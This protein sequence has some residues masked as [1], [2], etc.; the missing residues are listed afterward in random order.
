MRAISI[1]ARAPNDYREAFLFLSRASPRLPPSE[2]II[3]ANNKWAVWERNRVRLVAEHGALFSLSLSRARVVVVVA[4]RERDG[5]KSRSSRNAGALNKCPCCKVDRPRSPCA[6]SC[7]ILSASSI[8]WQ[9][10]GD[11]SLV[12]SFVTRFVKSQVKSVFAA[13]A[14]EIY[15]RV[16]RRFI[17]DSMRAC[18]RRINDAI[19]RNRKICLADTR[20]R[21]R[22]GLSVIRLVPRLNS[23]SHPSISNEP[24]PKRKRSDRSYV[25]LSL[26][27]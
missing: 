16:H 1:R 10:F 7:A 2:C 14:I 23:N 12:C 9:R 5:E 27:A 26:F 19:R 13:S 20:V 6:A 11:F 25:S 4:E 3:R 8:T 18:K 17:I 24:S 22:S 15:P 21:T